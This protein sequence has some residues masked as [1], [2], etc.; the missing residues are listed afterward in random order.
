MA[1]KTLSLSYKKSGVALYKVNYTN[2][3][4]HITDYGIVP[5][6]MQGSIIREVSFIATQIATMLSNAYIYGMLVNVKTAQDQIKSSYMANINRYI[7]FGG[8][9]GNNVKLNVRVDKGDRIYY[10]VNELDTNVSPTVDLEFVFKFL[11]H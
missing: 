11:Y 3:D 4:G 8:G 6:E 9:I 1:A 10:W 7:Q 2:S 5:A